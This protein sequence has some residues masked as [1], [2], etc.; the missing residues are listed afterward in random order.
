MA[1]FFGTT[2]RNFDNPKNKFTSALT[3]PINETKHLD[4]WPTDYEGSR[5]TFVTHS[6]THCCA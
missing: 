1:I 4:L 2:E 3:L 6:L 5:L